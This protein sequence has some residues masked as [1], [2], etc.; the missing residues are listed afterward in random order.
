MTA[1]QTV[2]KKFVATEFLDF[3]ML[4]CEEFKDGTAPE[5]EEE[6]KEEVVPSA[7]DNE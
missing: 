3:E 7:D 1:E 5:A 2:V 6:K 4:D